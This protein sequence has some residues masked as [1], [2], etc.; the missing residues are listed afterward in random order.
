MHTNGKRQLGPLDRGKANGT[1]IEASYMSLQKKPPPLPLKATY[2]K[3]R[4]WGCCSIS[5]ALI[6]LVF[7]VAVIV[8]PLYVLL[9]TDLV[10]HITGARRTDSQHSNNS[11]EENSVLHQIHRSVGVGTMFLEL[12]TTAAPI[13]RDL[14]ILVLVIDT[15]SHNIDGGAFKSTLTAWRKTEAAWK[16]MHDSTTIRDRLTVRHCQSCKAVGLRD[17]SQGTTIFYTVQHLKGETHS[18]N[19]VVFVAQPTPPGEILAMLTRY[20]RS[21]GLGDACQRGTWSATG[22][23]FLVGSREFKGLRDRAHTH[24]GNTNTGT[25]GVS[26]APGKSSS[27]SRIEKNFPQFAFKVQALPVTEIEL[28]E[29][30]M[31]IVMQKDVNMFKVLINRPIA[32][33]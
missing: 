25:S 22:C 31:T 16:D 30:N 33:R 23:D 29:F 26:T 8:T 19:M 9:F 4:R 1:Y 3:S 20:G 32:L 6:G 27:F 5:S 24:Q 14:N 15:R 11:T 28:L 13:L 21:D 17:D 7:F 18:F 12:A 2:K 10:K